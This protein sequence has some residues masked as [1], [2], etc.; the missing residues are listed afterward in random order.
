MHQFHA[1]K[2]F[3]EYMI[4]LNLAW[5]VRKKII[6]ISILGTGVSKVRCRIEDNIF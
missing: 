3:N 4:F 2:S 1:F 6:Q 5:V